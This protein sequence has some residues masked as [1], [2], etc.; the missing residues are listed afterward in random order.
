MSKKLNIR[1]VGASLDSSGYAA[2]SREY[3]RALIKRE[4]IELTTSIVSFE[5]QKTTHGSFDLQIRPYVEKPLPYTIQITHLTPENFPAAIKK[6]VYNI[7]YTAWETDKLPSRW[8][9]L[10]NMMKEIWVPSE[11]NKEVFQKSGVIVP[12]V[13]VPHILQ[14]QDTTDAMYLS[15]GVPDE[16]YVFY[17]IFQWIER[18]NPLALLKAY[19]T[20]FKNTEPV[21]LAIKTYGLDSSTGET[22]MIKAEIANLKASLRLSSF[23]TAR[24]FPS[25]LPREAIKGLHKRGN[26]FVLPQRAEGFGIP[27]AEA[28]AF[29]NPVISTGYGGCL[30][31]MTKSNSYL[32]DY[33]KTPVC[34]MRFGEYSGDMCWAEPSVMD[35]RKK[36]RYCFENR[37]KAKE[38]GLVGQKYVEE[39]L[40]QK[41]I[42]DLIVDRLNKINKG[43]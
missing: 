4:D 14:K 15:V 11:W 40:S 34:G 38:I 12:V 28:M 33:M 16:D 24:L 32:V 19:Y 9:P 20:E 42:G 3:L 2:A 39:N 8:V 29:G 35:L 1:W 18:K 37:D 23:P 21:C 30:E 22:E 43:L 7:G 5:K 26:C 10:C 41:R 13:A 27:L 17:S 6:D 31:F 36:M 25:L